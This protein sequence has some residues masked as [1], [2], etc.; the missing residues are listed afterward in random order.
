MNLIWFVISTDLGTQSL[1]EKKKSYHTFG[2]NVLDNTNVLT[3]YSIICSSTW[4]NL[5]GAKLKYYNKLVKT[6]ILVFQS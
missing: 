2:T 1:L 6:F 5:V 4:K 3:M